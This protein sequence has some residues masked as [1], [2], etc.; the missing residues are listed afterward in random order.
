[1]G[2]KPNLNLWLWILLEGLYI[3]ALTLKPAR[4]RWRQ[5]LFVA[6]FSIAGYAL[7]YYRTDY[8][9]LGV[10]ERGLSARLP[11]L[12]A[13]ASSNLMLCE[14][15]RDIR[16][17][18]QKANISELPF[19][20]RLWWAVLVWAN[21]R[22]VNF[23]H[24]PTANLPSR[25]TH[26]T[27]ISFVLEQLQSIL[28]YMLLLDLVGAMNRANPYYTK[29]V[30]VIV[31]MQRLW[32]IA[33]FG[34]GAAIWLLVS[35]QF[36][37][38]S[39]MLVLLGASNP[40]DCPRFFGSPFDGYTVRR[41]WSKF[42]HQMLRR[43]CVTHADFAAKALQ[44]DPNSKNTYILKLTVA[45]LLSGI[46]HYISEAVPA[47]SITEPLGC[48]VFF[49]LQTVA[50]VFEEFVIKLARAVGFGVAKCDR[51]RKGGPNANSEGK[52]SWWVRV[53]GYLWVL[54]WIDF[55]LPYWTAAGYRAG[56]TEEIPQF[57]VILGLWK[58]DWFPLNKPVM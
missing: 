5:L 14:P 35:M 30:P 52:P 51:S 3:L 8:R 40:N 10:G 22:G 24:E 16:L 54:L 31:G 48:L 44:L 11:I 50:I 28:G 26:T 41:V 23:A 49:L 56:W 58:G 6:I 27:H 15:H 34:F 9:H 53:V 32:W 2:S 21:P 57:S 36:M 18:G 25:P 17:I 37:F 43:P 7:V 1:M 29:D 45:F 19:T 20:E 12:V 46:I 33:G 38:L 47:E 4:H 55:S 39:I 42:W 13:F